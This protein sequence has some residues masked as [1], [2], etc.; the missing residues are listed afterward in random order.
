VPG[1]DLRIT[2]ADREDSI[3]VTLAGDLD[4]LGEERLEAELDRVW[5]RRPAQAVIDLRGL[6]FLDARGV[7]AIWHASERAEANGVTLRIVRAAEPVQ[8]IFRLL[9]LEGQLEF[10]SE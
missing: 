2:V 1:P 3:V 4:L 7:A 10:V 8:R 9:D 6:M 5:A